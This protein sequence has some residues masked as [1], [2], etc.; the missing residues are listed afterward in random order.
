VDERSIQYIA[1]AM[2]PEC[3]FRNEPPSP[4]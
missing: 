1:N 4:P 2:L 3:F